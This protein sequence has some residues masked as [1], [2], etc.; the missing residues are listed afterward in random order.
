MDKKPKKA[1]FIIAFKD[2]RDPEYFIPKEILNKA[3]ITTFCASSKQGTAIGVEGGEEDVDIILE[4][5]KVKDYDAIIFVGGIGAAGYINNPLAHKIAQDAVIERK[6]L[7]G[8]CIGPTILAKA[9]VLKGVKA[10]VWSS[11]M[12]KSA[13]RI[14]QDQKALYQPENVVIDGKIIT[15]DGP[16]SAQAFAL[17]IVKALG[18]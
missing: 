6:I 10:T 15:A 18:D 1:V 16:G 17:A 9:G 8:I 5:V 11:L 12:D 7:A 2:F 4:Q 3:G 14:L 13:I